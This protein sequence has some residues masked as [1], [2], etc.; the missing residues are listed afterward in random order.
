M[1]RAIFM[2]TVCAFVAPL[3]AHAAQFEGDGKAPV[4]AIA[5]HLLQ[6]GGAHGSGNLP[7]YI[8]LD[9]KTVDFSHPLPAV[10][11]ALLIFHGKLRN[12]DDYNAT[13]ERAIRT[14]G[15]AAEKSTL[16]I[17]PQFLDQVDVD[18]YHLPATTLRWT[19]TGWMGGSN[20]LD[21]A[22]A[23]AGPS[24]FA[25]IDAIL[26]RLADRKLFPNLK[27]VVLA[28]HSGGGQVVQRYA[29]V[30]RGGEALVH[31]GVHV[32][33]VVANPSSYVYFSLERPVRDAKTEFTYALP[34]KTCYGKYNKWKYGIEDTPPYVDDADFHELEERYVRRDVIYLLGI[35]DNDPNNPVLDK[36][37]A[38]ED[39][40]PYRFFRGKAYFRYLELRHSVLGTEAASQKLDYVPGVG[41][42]GDKMLNSACGLTALFD[43]GTCTTR[44]LDPKP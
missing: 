5:D 30:G 24:S 27:N 14:A 29:V 35:A 17:T 32:R 38:G 42:D 33:Y 2:I 39:E 13:G 11:R 36:S 25:A 4:K 28:G 19:P 23:A 31:A 16:L 7:L 12:A 15:R 1:R 9:G 41:H 26:E 40:G 20:A 6:V 10:T 44:M 37:C 22:A 43:A 34:A 3:M 8:S 18:A 21:A